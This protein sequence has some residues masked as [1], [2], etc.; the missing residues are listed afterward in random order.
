MAQ[1]APHFQEDATRTAKEGKYL[2]FTLAREGYGLEILKVREI[3]GIMD[4]TPLP[5][6][7]PYM[8]GVINLRGRIIPVIDLRLRFDMQ[9]AAYTE[10]SCIIVVEVENGGNRVPIGV[11]VDAVSEVLN[12]GREE[13]EPPPSFAVRVQSDYL[14]GIA[15]TKG[16]IKILLDL[17]WLLT[18]AELITLEEVAA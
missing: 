7:P 11:V 5:Q 1:A 4:I 12:I 6:M 10:R 18:S 9:G 16:G 3:I 2:T 8:T 14:L 15:K 13:I 17:Q